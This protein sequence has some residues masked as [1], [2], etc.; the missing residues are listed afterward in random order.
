MIQRL[1]RNPGTKLLSLAISVFLWIMLARAP[2]VGTFVSVPLEYQG[3]ADDL[4]ISSDVVASV[5]IDLRGPSNL[6]RSFGA[7]PAPVALNLAKI[8]RPGEQT[9]DINER[10]VKLPPGLRLVRAVPAQLRLQFERRV[11]RDVAVQA[12]FAGAPQ[13]GFVMARND[14]TPRTMTLVGPESRVNRVEFVATDPIDVTAVAGEAI[15]EV[16]VFSGDPHVRFQKP[17]KVSVKVVLE[18]Q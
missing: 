8:H 15:F 1:F 16:N 11:T 3:M 7:A 4:E 10:N 12:R 18:K 13:Q 9:F 17:A 5:S 14:V 6:V 2:E